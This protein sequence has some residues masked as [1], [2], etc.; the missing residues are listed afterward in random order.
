MSLPNAIVDRQVCSHCRSIFRAGFSR[1]PADGNELQP[2]T[3]D[4]LV[5]STFAERFIIEACIG[6]GGMGRVYRAA[7]KHMSR[8]FAIKVLFGDLAADSRMQLRFANEAE[9]ASRMSHRNLVSVLDFSETA[10]KQLFLVMDYVEGP[11]L[12]TLIRTQAPLKTNRAANLLWQLAAGLGHAHQNGLIHRD[13]KP[14]NV[15]V[16]KDEY[17]E[18][19]KILDFGIAR[20][21]DSE[22]MQVFTTEGTVMGTPAYMSPEQASAGK[23]DGRTD[24]FSLGVGLYEMLAG[25]LPF[26]GSPLNVVQR[27]ITVTPP[28]IG[29]RAPG[30][31]VDSFLEDVAFRLMAKKPADRYQSAWAVIAAIASH[32]GLDPAV[33]QRAKLAVPQPSSPGFDGN[34]ESNMLVDVSEA[35]IPHSEVTNPLDL[36]AHLLAETDPAGLEAA[37]S[38]LHLGSKKL[39]PSAG[40]V[41]RRRWPTIGVVGLSLAVIV[42]GVVL[43][44]SMMPSKNPAGER[45]AEYRAEQPEQ[46][47]PSAV[48]TGIENEAGSPDP[49][50]PEEVAKSSRRSSSKRERRKRRDRANKRKK[51]KDTPRPPEPREIMYDDF[52]ALD[53]A[54]R[55]EVAEFRGEHAGNAT[56]KELEEELKRINRAAGREASARKESYGLLEGIRRRLRAEKRRLERK[57]D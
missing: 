51:T 13:F 38:T 40:S 54:V 47:E 22:H 52:K 6:E 53:R 12:K 8:R 35:P 20:I 33:R 26:E 45:Q 5:G 57:I 34:G 10:D 15:I 16:A 56:G 30:L 31:M 32:P 27:N 41:R 37:A 36:P 25:K 7:H 1:C 17:G 55:N 44:M 11:S 19:P 21:M 14:E 49:A 42:A 43:G 2:L 24:L 18:T 4:P 50:P 39:D 28:R 23:L 9:A 3:D 46:P 29:E 48:V